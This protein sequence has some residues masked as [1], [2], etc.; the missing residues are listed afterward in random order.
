MIAQIAKNKGQ[1]AFFNDF[2]HCASLQLKSGGQSRP[3]KVQFAA[4]DTLTFSDVRTSFHKKIDI[5]N[6]KKE[7]AFYNLGDEYQRLSKQTYFLP[8]REDDQEINDDNLQ[9]KFVVWNMG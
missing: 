1:E 2:L 6:K 9:S 7:K 8:E 3:F 4:H 5:D